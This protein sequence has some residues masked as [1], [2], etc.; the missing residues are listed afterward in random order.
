MAEN[1]AAS[2]PIPSSDKEKGRGD[3]CGEG[4]TDTMEGDLLKNS[5]LNTNPGGRNDEEKVDEE[6]V[7]Q[8]AVMLRCGAEV[9]AFYAQGK[10][11]GSVQFPIPNDW[12]DPEVCMCVFVCAIG[13]NGR[14]WEE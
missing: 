12:N 1:A 7:V 14:K 2:N 3:E 4:N 6:P 10:C 11:V 9:P 8:S 5:R 13:R